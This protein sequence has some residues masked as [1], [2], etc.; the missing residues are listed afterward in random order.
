[1]LQAL[2][3]E[4]GLP[5]EVH[6]LDQAWLDHVTFLL[7]SS[8]CRDEAVL[9]TLPPCIIRTNILSWY[10]WQIP[11]QSPTF[12]CLLFYVYLVMWGEGKII[13]LLLE[14]KV[15]WRYARNHLLILCGVGSAKL[16]TR[17]IRHLHLDLCGCKSNGPDILSEKVMLSAWSLQCTNL[18]HCLEVRFAN[19][20]QM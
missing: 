9:T 4:R 7:Q 19:L 15:G 6:R 20:C 1:M 12:F 10:G 16:C 17:E 14:S 5:E 2:L 18:V 13:I 3:S 8:R 11:F